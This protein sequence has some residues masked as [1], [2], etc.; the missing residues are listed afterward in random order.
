MLNRL[1]LLAVALLLLAPASFAQK[2]SADVEQLLRGRDAQIKSIIGSGQI[3]KTQREQL[4]DVVNDV[5]DFEA[6]AKTA[7]G[8]TWSTLSATQ[9]REFVDV[10]AG[11]VRAQSLADLDAYRAK[12]GYGA[13]KVSGNTATASTT[14]TYKNVS[15]TVVY[16]LVYKNNAWRVTDITIDGVSTAES[17]ANS[18]QRVVKQ[19]GFDT[20]MA[21]LRKR[22]ARLEAKA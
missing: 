2:S 10:F 17:Y 12:V 7:L 22:L 18:F 14:T 8:P 19:R 3:S 15:S 4:R 20:L 13:V 21:S 1:L 9:R 5:I 6:M 16:D 11:I